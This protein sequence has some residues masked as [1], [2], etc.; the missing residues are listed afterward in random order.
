M[1]PVDELTCL[2]A[3]QLLDAYRTRSLSPVEVLDAHTAR[4]AECD[5]T[6]G[7]FTTLC[8]ERARE[9]AARAASAYREGVAL[10][11]A[12]VPIGVKDLFE[13][14]GVRTTYG[15]TM[16]AEHVPGKDADAVRRVREAGAIVVGK[17][18]THEFAW[19]VSSVNAAMGTSHNPWD[20]ERIS[21]GSSG[22]SA[23]ALAGHLVTLALGSDTGGS[24]RVPASFCGT[25]GLKPTYGRIDTGGVFPLAPSLDHVGPMARN[26]ADVALLFDVLAGSTPG[27]TQREDNR[28]S[29]LR[30]GVCPDL[31]LVALAPEI[32]AAFDDA[33]RAFERLGADVIEVRIPEAEGAYETFGTIQR[34]EALRTHV[35][36]GLFPAR[37]HEYGAD[38]LGRLE[39]AET[40][41]LRDYLEATLARDKLR[42]GFGRALAEVDLVITPVSAGPPARIGEET[43]THLG[44]EI[45]F[46]ELVMS[47][48]T[49]QDLTGLPSCTVR[50][51]FDAL[52]IPTA[53]Q[54]TGRPWAERRVL[55]AAQALFDA[56][57]DTQARWPDLAASRAA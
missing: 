50:A 45:E 46:R 1:G 39:L 17:T 24:I 22:G 28:R 51:G 32:R 5:P 29:R 25:V 20:P 34:C 26:P 41:E 9:E 15:S 56:T 42:A 10:P 49:P 14:A 8:L 54:L 27:P 2:G 19:G 31:H 52:G 12:G 36:A 23:V 48:T 13:T 6:L 57:P 47:Y 35:D 40:M 3:T 43:V 44:R 37:R 30:I 7:A 55:E 4:I 21:G 38:V 16:F 18:Q 33:V 11:L 53:V